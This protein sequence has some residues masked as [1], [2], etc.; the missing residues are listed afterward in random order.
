MISQ[1][2][3]SS[4]IRSLEKGSATGNAPTANESK[5]AQ[6]ELLPAIA[7]KYQQEGE[8]LYLL[9]VGEI[10]GRQRP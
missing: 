10:A 6:T 2:G 8:V 5:I 4:L 9:L 1:I 7:P 3:C